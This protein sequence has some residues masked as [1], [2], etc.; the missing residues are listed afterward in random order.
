M[1]LKRKRKRVDLDDDYVN[2]Q[3]N[4]QKN[5][6]GKR[7]VIRFPDLRNRLVEIHGRYNLTTDDVMV[8]TTVQSQSSYWTLL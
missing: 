3:H 8:H 2:K 1:N 4:A 5:L 6:R 7:K